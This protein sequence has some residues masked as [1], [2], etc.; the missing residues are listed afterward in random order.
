MT[1]KAEL[2]IIT[3]LRAM[4]FFSGLE[5]VHLKK[6]ASIATEAEFEKGEIIYREGDLDQAMYLVQKGEVVIEMKT[7]EQSYATV[8]KVGPKQLFG[9]SSLFPGQRKRARARSLK[10]THVFI[11][12]G[13]RLN[14]L[15]QADHKLENVVMRRMIKLVA[16]RVYATRQQLI[17]PYSTPQS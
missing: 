6:L 8:L 2:E 3:A 5:T 13:E 15:F 1:S 16:E 9:W 4:E 7:P 12:N 14:H 17:E 10:H 11:L